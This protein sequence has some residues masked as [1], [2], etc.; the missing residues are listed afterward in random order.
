M[1]P[2]FTLQRFFQ[3]LTLPRAAKTNRAGQFILKKSD[4]SPHGGLLELMPAWMTCINRFE[5]GAGERGAT[6]GWMLLCFSSRKTS[7]SLGLRA[8][9]NVKTENVRAGWTKM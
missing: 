5:S 8:G 3:M 1:N 4:R 2:H 6:E 9:K 7:I